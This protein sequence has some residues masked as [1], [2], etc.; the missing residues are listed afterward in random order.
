MLIHPPLSTLTRAGLQ[1]L[2]GQVNPLETDVVRLRVVPDL[3]SAVQ[4]AFHAERVARGLVLAAGYSPV[5]VVKIRRNRATTQMR[6]QVRD[7]KHHAR[8]SPPPLGTRRFPSPLAAVS[9][10]G[11]GGVGVSSRLGRGWCQQPV[12]E[13]GLSPL[14]VLLCAAARACR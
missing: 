7:K 2:S 6:V 4:A 9:A 14:L 8:R 1:S 3:P 11:L 13:G 12:W 10:A 5:Y